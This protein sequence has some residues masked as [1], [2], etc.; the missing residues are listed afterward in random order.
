MLCIVQA[1]PTLRFRSEAP[2]PHSCSAARQRSSAS[3]SPALLFRAQSAAAAAKKLSTGVSMPL[4]IGAMPRSA[5]AVG[6][7]H[8]PLDLCQSLCQ[9]QA[10]IGICAPT[11]H[12]PSAYLIHLICR[13]ARQDTLAVRSPLWSCGGLGTLACSPPCLGCQASRVSHTVM[14]SRPL[15]S[16]CWLQMVACLSPA[17]ALMCLAACRAAPLLFVMWRRSWPCRGPLAPC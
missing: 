7:P 11:Q 16:A 1:Q 14:L 3:P 8:Q 12:L 6:Q 9:W 5:F 10:S 4:V 17:C 2:S 15:L 13:V